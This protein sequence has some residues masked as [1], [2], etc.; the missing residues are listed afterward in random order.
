MGSGG[1]EH[2]LAWK[3]N[4]SE[5]LTK[6]YVAPGN[7]GTAEIAEN[8]NIKVT[9]FEALANFVEH[10]AIDMLVVGPE[11]PLVEGIRDYF[12]ADARFAR[13][14]IV[15]PGKAGAILEGSKDFAKEFMFRHHIPTAGYLTVTKDNLEKGFAFLETLKPPY[16]LKA[17]GLAAGKGVLILDNLEEAKRELE[18]MLGGK[19]GKAGNQVVIEEYLKGIELSVFALTDGKSYKILGSAKDYKRIGEG[20]MGLNT[21][22]MGAVSPVPFANEEFNRKVEERVVRP[23]IEGLQKDGIDY[24]GFVFFGLMNVGG[25]PYVI[26]YNVRMGDPETE[27]VMPRLKTDVLSLFEAMAKGELEQAAFE[28]DDRFCTTVM[29]VSQGYP[30]DYEKGKE[31]TGVPDVKGSIVFHAGTKLAEGKVVTNGGRVIAVSSFGKTMREALAQ[32]YKNVAKIH[33]DGMNF[34]RDIGFDL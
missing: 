22:G 29:L 17:D 14:M 28:L 10:N 11:D 25:D 6:L 20:D 24:K 19:F 13:L 18:L 23:T 16:V 32:S 12:E 34:R 30:G 21:G 33:F 4:Q 15:G 9:D 31:I 2:A 7:A 3:I 5:R 27:V 26:E 1:R 8:V